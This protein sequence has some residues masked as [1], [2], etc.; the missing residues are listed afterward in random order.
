MVNGLGRPKVQ[1]G[2]VLR[3]EARWCALKPNAPVTGLI[4]LPLPVG[5]EPVVLGFPR[6]VRT[7]VEV[8]D[9]YHGGIS[10][11]EAV[12]P[13][14]VSR[15]ALGSTRLEVDVSVGTTDVVT[16]TIAVAV[17]PAPVRLFDQQPTRVR[18]WVERMSVPEDPVA[19]P[20]EVEVRA[21][22]NEIKPPLYLK[23]G[24]RIRA[25]TDLVLRV[26][27]VEN[28]REVAT[29]PLRMLVDWD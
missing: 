6:G 17:R 5:K 16:G 14:A 4:R 9:F 13:H 12:I 29:I 10:L 7:L 27:D 19:E 28:G 11:Q 25:G 22:V 3:R 24:S 15:A 2:Q 26:V 18:L 1:V 23:E 21:D 20:V 8:G